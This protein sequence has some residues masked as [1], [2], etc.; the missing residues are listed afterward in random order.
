MNTQRDN[1]KAGLFVLVGIV[2]AVAVIIILADFGAF[3]ASEQKIRVYYALNDGL[4]GLKPGARVNLGGQPV[5]EVVAI[6]D[7]TRPGG[8]HVEGKIV[9]LSVPARYRVYWTAHIEVEKPPLGTNTT[10]NIANVGDK[11]LLTAEILPDG[12]QVLKETVVPF[13]DNN[14]PIPE[15]VYRQAFPERRDGLAADSPMRPLP[16][17]TIPGQIAGTTLTK[18]LTQDIGIGELQRRQIAEMIDDFH[19][20][21]DNL[22]EMSKDLRKVTGTLG[23]KSASVGEI[24][25]NV[26]A[27]SA[28]LKKEVPEIAAQAKATLGKADGIFED[29]RL[30]MADVKAAVKD[31]RDVVADAKQRSQK[32]F[33]DIDAV[34]AAAN[35]GVSRLR[36]LI[37]EKSPAVGESIDNLQMITRTVK[38]KTLV[39]IESAL[40]KANSALENTRVATDEVKSL[41]IGQR[42]VLE[43]F[44]ANGQ[45][46]SAQLKL[47][48]IEVR[49]SPWR[50]LYSPDE[51]E[52]ET[53]NLYDAARSFALAAS[54][55][56][57]AADS[58]RTMTAKDPNNAAQIKR[59]LDD[60][61]KLYV[62]Y[63][64]AEN[65]FWQALKDRPKPK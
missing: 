63:K 17:G 16:P 62:K 54:T 61:E 23:E 1:V 20:V 46:M 42:P 9:T 49:R 60:L 19:L 57:A 33:G 45:L 43:R 55:L 26:N 65:H 53:D 10:M 36:D 14:Q 7:Y 21:A 29:A 32:W 8:D 50:L 22:R 6:D 64:D 56:D 25:D 34:T 38:E 39:Q 13:Y 30:A 59:M 3:F 47:A 27:A 40:D 28:S 41:V 4:Q 52:L 12:T 51:K 11:A 2:L 15:P 35:E 58:L 18:S 24:L 37:K 44:F 5:G 48:A 31:A